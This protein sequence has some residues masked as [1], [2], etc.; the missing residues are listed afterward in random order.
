MSTYFAQVLPAS[1]DVDDEDLVLWLGTRPGEIG[2]PDGMVEPLA[3]FAALLPAMIEQLKVASELPFRR[4]PG[5][6][7][8]D[9]RWKSVATRT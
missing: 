5:S 2:S 4:Q 6:L 1:D 3:P 9:Q 7:K 8:H